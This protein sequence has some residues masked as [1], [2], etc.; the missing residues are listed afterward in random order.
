[1]STQLVETWL[2]HQCSSIPG[3]KSG[4]IAIPVENSSDRLVIHWPRQEKP[5]EHLVNGLK[6]VLKH[7]RPLIQV[8]SNQKTSRT[9]HGVIGAPIQLNETSF[10]AASLSL[11][12]ADDEK[13]K[14]ALKQL[15]QALSELR[16]SLK[17]ETDEQTN[18][19]TLSHVTQLLATSLE[20]HGFEQ[21]AL[22]TC[23]ELASRMGCER[24]SLSYRKKHSSELIALS[25][26]TELKS[27]RELVRSLLTVMDEAI[28]QRASITYNK[29]AAEDR[30]ITLAHRLFSRDHGN[31]NLTTVPLVSHDE[32]VGALL[33]EKKADSIFT[34]AEATALENL[35]CFLAPVFS[36]KYA[37]ER[38]FSQRFKT[39]IGEFLNNLKTG[40]N[41]LAKT[42][43]AAIVGLLI[44]AALP[45]STYQIGAPALLEGAVQRSITAPVDGF[46]KRALAKPGDI[47]GENE[48]IA[49]L[50]DEDL[51][52]EKQK[53]TSRLA[54]L[55]SSFST[56]MAKRDLSAVATG[57]AEVQEIE[58]ELALL[59]QQ[60]ER[61][62]IT[63]PFSGE[64]IEGDLFQSLGAPVRRGDVMMTL[65]PVNDYRVIFHVEES[66]I[67]EIKKGFSGALAL[68]SNP[69][70]KHAI[71]VK[72]VT[73]LATVKEG[74]NV[75]EVE[76]S[77]K[78]KPQTTFR[79]G[80]EGV[81][82]IDIGER[83]LLW[84]SLHSSWEWL[85]LKAWKW[86]GV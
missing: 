55:Q 58:A 24:V 16:Q 32:I 41:W 84:I 59:Q 64:I 75:F 52:L 48:V 72:R 43:A 60:L 66:D 61:T 36:M 23:N 51:L 25:N 15:L 10:A 33:F 14:L 37:L 2:A 19:V 39:G 71:V 31:H 44:V 3:V 30:F 85:R 18:H 78:G 57:R 73:P 22:A 38:P 29:H 80:M 13:A 45:I 53:L 4:V 63:A 82:K 26:T 7:H 74:K 65:A 67:D 81:V 77:L 12:N 42:V 9:A 76:A 86:L 27:S 17:N 35:S 83:S 6:N 8:A 1:M 54:Q 56:A 46:I 79:P 69:S 62:Q 28:D 5:V 49:L 21:S 11:V 70:Q 20:I 68:A 47:V 34:K 40:K 50:D